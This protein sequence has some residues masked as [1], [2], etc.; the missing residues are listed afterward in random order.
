LVDC[1]GLPIPGSG[2]YRFPFARQHAATLLRHLQPDV[3]EAGDPYRLAWSVRDAARWLDVPAVAFCH[4]D[5]GT[6]AATAFG[7]RGRLARAARRLARAYLRRTY[8]G[9]DLVLAPS[10]HV[11]RMLRELG[12]ERVLWQRLGVDTTLFHPSR[13]D[14]HWRRSLGLPAD[15]RLLLYVGRFAPEKHLQVLADAVARLG[16]GYRLLCVGAGPCPPRGAQVRLLPYCAE[17]AEL[18]RIIASVDG[19]V[20]AGDQETFGLSVLEAMACGTPVAVRGAAGL[21]EQV[22]SGAGIGVSTNEPAAWADGIEALF[23]GERA[24][25]IRIALAQA[26]RHDWNAVLPQ[27]LRR[28]RRLMSSTTRSGEPHRAAQHEPWRQVPHGE[29]S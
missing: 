17:P 3:V 18:A 19:V 5:V 10:R 14:P 27:L 24:T 4:S 2:G 1:G 21:G 6:L 28:Y 13:R 12:L 7:G 22:A 8:D 25:R 20:H 9:F 29:H 23:D 26:A 15:A 11:G 16:P